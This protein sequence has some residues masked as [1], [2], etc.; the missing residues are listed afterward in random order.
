VLA[1]EVGLDSSALEVRPR[2]RP[3]SGSAAYTLTVGARGPGAPG[4]VTVRVHLPSALELTPGSLWGGL[5]SEPVSGRLV[6]RGRLAAGSRQQVGWTARL[7]PGLD[8]GARAM[9]R[10]VVGA[11][12]VQAVRL[13]AAVEASA[14]DLSTSS[15]VMRPRIARA[16]EEVSVVLRAANT[17]PEPAVVTLTDA[18]PSAL[19]LVSG[20]L[21]ASRGEAEWDE[22]AQ[23][24]RWVGELGPSEAVEVRLRAVF[25]GRTAVRNVMVVTDLDGTRVS[26]WADV[27]P[28]AG[29]AYLPAARAR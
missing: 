9:T 13:A 26:A 28:L 18:L 23:S 7:A 27:A 8:V 22:P 4:E 21:R 3:A 6:W 24:V 19:T 29:T 1:N 12:G 25:D 10:A 5:A 17:G 14:S 20:S 15:K 11:P 2:A 16:G